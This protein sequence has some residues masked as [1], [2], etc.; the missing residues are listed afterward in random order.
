MA[1]STFSLGM[2]TPLAFCIARRSCGLRSGSGPPALTAMTMSFPMR[3]NCFAIRSY[4]ANIVCLR[5][6]NMRPMRAG[7]GEPRSYRRTSVPPATPSAVVTRY[8]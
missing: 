3:V 1:P 6:S 7:S 4:R 8:R 5:F 2:L